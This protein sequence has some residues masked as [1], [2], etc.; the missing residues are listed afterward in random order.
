MKTK[1]QQ[2]A[3]EYAFRFLEKSSVLSR[4]FGITRQAIESWRKVAK[5]PATRVHSIVGKVRAEGGKL[6]HHELRPDVFP[7]NMN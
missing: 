1:T 4:Q 3:T 2:E 7:K 6:T 5:V